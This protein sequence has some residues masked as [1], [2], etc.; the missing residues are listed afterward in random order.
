MKRIV[1]FQ[2][3]APAVEAYDDDDSELKG[4]SDNISQILENANVTILELSTSSVVVRPSKVVS[5][6]VYNV[7]D[8]PNNLPQKKKLK[9]LKLKKAKEDHEDIITDAD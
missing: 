2:E 4:Y 1:I 7:D 3:N 8:P 6:A 5:I 9:K